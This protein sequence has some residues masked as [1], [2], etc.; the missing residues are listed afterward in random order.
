[1]EMED[2]LIDAGVFVLPSLFEPWGVVV[3]EF[4]AAG[5]PMVLSDKIGASEEFLQIGHNG[6]DFDSSSELDLTKALAL[7]IQLEES[8]LIKFAKES[9]KLA[10]KL[11]PQIWTDTLLRLL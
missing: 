10:Q 9:H 4:A 11:N 1:M 3:Q 2:Y 6:Y 7:I 5:F 8:V